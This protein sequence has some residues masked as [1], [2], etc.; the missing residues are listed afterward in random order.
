MT[1]R[2]RKLARAAAVAAAVFVAAWFTR[3][4]PL[5]AASAG[6]FV[7]RWT[8]TVYYISANG[9]L[10]VAAERSKDE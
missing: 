4:Q 1:D 3:F 8:G 2:K 9:E 7:N 10:K 6:A 5:P